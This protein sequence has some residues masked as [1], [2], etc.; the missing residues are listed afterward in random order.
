VPFAYTGQ[1]VQQGDWLVFNKYSLA[2]QIEWEYATTVERAS[3]LVE[4]IGAGLVL[5]DA[6]MDDLFTQAD[7]L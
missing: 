4:A 7:Q 6:H 2:V 3:P 5:T 1:D